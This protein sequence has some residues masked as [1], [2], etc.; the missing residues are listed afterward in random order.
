MNAVKTQRPR[1]PTHT[2]STVCDP[3]NVPVCTITTPMSMPQ[4]QPI[5]TSGTCKGELNH[6]SLSI[7][8]LVVGLVLGSMLE[9]KTIV[10]MILL[11]II[12]DNRPLPFFGSVKPMQ[13]INQ[14]T[15]HMTRFVADF[16][17]HSI[18]HS[19]TKQD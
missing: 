1:K 7:W 9:T 8:Y 6:T 15:W 16:I 19:I 10:V 18:S 11:G 13:L 4:P 5:E 3:V 12:I 17:S 14:L 2:K